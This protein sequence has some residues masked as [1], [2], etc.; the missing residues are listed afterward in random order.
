MRKYYENTVVIFLIESIEYVLYGTIP[1]KE[2]IDK[3][4]YLFAESIR[5]V[6]EKEL[7]LKWKSSSLEFVISFFKNTKIDLSP[8]N[9]KI[10]YTTIDKVNDINCLSYLKNSSISLSK[11]RKE[12]LKKFIIETA[13]S[14]NEMND[15]LK[16]NEYLNDESIVSIIDKCLFHSVSEKFS[17]VLDSI[18]ENDGVFISTLF[19]SYLLFLIKIK[20]NRNIEPSEVSAE[21]IFIR[22]LWQTDYYIKSQKSLKTFSK[23]INISKD[24][25]TRHNN[26]ILENPLAVAF[27]CLSLNEMSMVSILESLSN[28]A[29]ILFVSKISINEDFPCQK[30]I[31]IDSRH[32]I[33]MIFKDYI[34]RIKTKKAYKLLNNFSTDKFIGEIY[35]HIGAIINTTFSTFTND[36][37][38]Y[39]YVV[40][41]NSDYC[42]IEYNDKLTLAHLT[43]LFPIIESKIRNIGEAFGIPPICEELDKYYKLKEPSTILGKIISFVY[44]ETKELTLCCDF[45]FVY[46]SMYGENGLNIRNDCIHGKEYN[47]SENEIVLAF[48]I[49][50]FCL[51]ILDERY[52]LI[53]EKC[54]ENK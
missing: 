53:C 10:Y 42:L 39:E 18:N 4:F 46:F 41:S 37:K 43:Q 17:E 29:M 54:K 33:D 12:Y 44:N 15:F 40:N 11:N 1:S 24:D 19:L 9:K 31:I 23:S 13:N 35:E 38:L 28:S 45:L 3:H 22:E 52:E 25:M 27:N 51:H 2:T 32:S 30:S 47:K 21:I 6:D 16:L 50:L 36:K 5:N 34:D 20:N 49:T 14:I 8:E 26:L 48:R 7:N